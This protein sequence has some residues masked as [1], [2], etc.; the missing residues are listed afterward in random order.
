MLVIL[1]CS[2]WYSS[3]CYF[4]SS[5]VIIDSFAGVLAIQLTTTTVVGP[6]FGADGQRAGDGF[7]H[8]LADACYATD[9]ASCRGFKGLRQ[10]NRHD[11][12]HNIGVVVVIVVY[13]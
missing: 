4:D 5:S 10:C 7:V 12:A 11:F 6:I 2:G 9:R 8:S 3:R 13:E 1:K